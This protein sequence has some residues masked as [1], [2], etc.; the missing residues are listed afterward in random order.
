M[1]TLGV[2][3]VAA[4][5]SSSPDFT[6]S[7]SGGAGGSGG[8]GGAAGG[9]AGHGCQPCGSGEYCQV[10][11]GKCVGCGDLSKLDFG[12]PEPLSAV[13]KNPAGG[14]RFPRVAGPDGSALVYVAANNTM[15]PAGRQ[16]WFAPNP[17][18]GF[19]AR[20][21]DSSWS[22][23]GPLFVQFDYVKSTTSH[24]LYDKVDTTGSGARD[25]YATE[26]GSGTV[27]SSGSLGGP[28]NSAQGADDYSIAVAPD[29]HRA[30]WMSDRGN[31][32]R[33]LL[34]FSWDPLGTP[35][36][37][38]LFDQNDCQRAGDDATPWVTPDG[39]VLLYSATRL[40]AG[41]HPA[42]SS[43]R[44]LYWI[45]LDKTTGRPAFGTR[46]QPLLESDGADATDPSLSRDLCTLYYAADD[47]KGFKLYRAP[48]R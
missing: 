6:S 17:D 29:V 19:G 21:S 5:C 47:G 11:T 18:S 33:Q 31:S 14:L 40:D 26:L 25:L 23:S 28:F 12:P 30:W 1:L 15:T 16:I 36:S 48:R 8:S 42:N 20:A 32:G 22:A 37:V 35:Q 9:D 45:K 13:N 46:G 38:N 41:C 34:T 27:Q 7:G 44:V 2:V 39:S 4:A 10:S 3:L 24:F 43:R